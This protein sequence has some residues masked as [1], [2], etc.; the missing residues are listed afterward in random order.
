M[1]TLSLHV[2]LLLALSV[3]VTAQV[4]HSPDQETIPQASAA[5]RASLD[6]FKPFPLSHFGEDDAL[7]DDSEARIKAAQD[8]LEAAEK[9]GNPFDK[10][11]ALRA[12]A[13]TRDPN[14]VYTPAAWRPVI[15]AWEEAGFTPGRIESLCAEATEGGS[16]AFVIDAGVGRKLHLVRALARTE[17]AYPLATARTLVNCSLNLERVALEA[18]SD[19]GRLQHA[20]GGIDLGEERIKGYFL[21]SSAAQIRGLSLMLLEEARLLLSERAPR[22]PEM[23][24]TLYD[25]AVLQ[26]AMG[27]RAEARQSLAAAD[28]LALETNASP[29]AR[30]AIA[31]RLG[32]FADEE[33][34]MSVGRRYEA[35]A[36]RLLP[37]LRGGQFDARSQLTYAAFCIAGGNEGGQ[38]AR[39][40]QVVN[41]WL[42][43]IEDT[44]AAGD[45]P[46]HIP[47]QFLTGERDKDLY[48]LQLRFPFYASDVER[49]VCP[50][51][52][53]AKECRETMRLAG[54]SIGDEDVAGIADQ[55]R[56]LTRARSRVRVRHIT[57]PDDLPDDLQDEVY[58]LARVRLFAD[59]LAFMDHT[60]KHLLP[61]KMAAPPHPSSGLL[62]LERLLPVARVDLAEEHFYERTLSEISRA[63]IF[64]GS[65][66]MSD[67]TRDMLRHI[68]SRLVARLIAA[69]EYGKAWRLVE[70]LRLQEEQNLNRE[71]EL[72]FKA[73]ESAVEKTRTGNTD[74]E[75][76]TASPDEIYPYLESVR[77]AQMTA[78]TSIADVTDALAGRQART[79]LAVATEHLAEND[80]ALDAL[81]L[82][83]VSHIMAR[84]PYNASLESV[85]DID[86]DE[87]K[88]VP[89]AFAVEPPDPTKVLA[90][91]EV[92]V[93]FS[94][95]ADSVYAFVLRRGEKPLGYRIPITSA[96]LLTLIRTFRQGTGDPRTSEAELARNGRRIFA[97]LFPGRA[98]SVVRDARRLIISPEGQLWSVPFAALV[99]N[100]VGE[101]EYLGAEKSMFYTH[102]FTSIAHGAPQLATP[103][104]ADE[105]L[106]LGLSHFAE[107]V[108][109]TLSYYYGRSAPSELEQAVAEADI[110]A[111]VYGTRALPANQASERDVRARIGQAD[112]I[113]IATHGFVFPEPTLAM[114]SGIVLGPLGGAPTKDDDGTLQAWEVLTELRLKARL[115][116]LSACETGIA[117]DVSADSFGRLIKSF[118]GAGA[119][120][121]VAS[122]WL[123]ADES[124]SEFMEKFHRSLRRGL[125]KD[126]AMREAI[127]GLRANPETHHPYYWAP[128]ILAG[129]PK[130]MWVP[131]RVGER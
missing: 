57:D 86:E 32:R 121:V 55:L 24:A 103:P 58:D 70:R 104:T 83:S 23:V 116:V 61:T 50:P 108:N 82:M 78:L 42:M 102:S 90:P 59:L 41:I 75:T 114:S 74:E 46:P 1:K 28:R 33:G 118:Q 81:E 6:R 126:D 60:D 31:Y 18:L 110:V 117:S 96:R 13:L 73:R 40:L 99:S 100:A 45:L 26:S 3:T 30:A 65:D 77:G 35:L 14:E 80:S 7:E 43:D 19:Y 107:P 53:N 56:R 92:Y 91:G 127:S 34:H 9:T 54:H 8:A 15:T 115:V 63:G 66:P 72:I 52:L 79:S 105:V 12:I 44:V 88:D 16:L 36:E 113:H 131:G 2:L 109:E 4:G 123:V 128:F 20:G 25:L 47:Y 64:S 95:G 89:D 101:P 112:I 93:A 38:P 11:L 122:Q 106:V 39:T 129:S 22:S 71:R 62:K 68:G 48:I 51:V 69:G 87:L 98:G 5:V 49:G 67:G 97:L 37:A 119:G 120:G 27:A 76:Q 111:D 85:F 125:R 94:L 29:E 10:A 84:G 21:P 130:S 124:T 17:R